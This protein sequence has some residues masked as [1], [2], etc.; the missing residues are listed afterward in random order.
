MHSVLPANEC[1]IL[2]F[3][4]KQRKLDFRPNFCFLMT[5]VL[6]ETLILKFYY[7]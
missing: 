4:V 5:H 6:Y 3:L 1:Q 2:F 7:F